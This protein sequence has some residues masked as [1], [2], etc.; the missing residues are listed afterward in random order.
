MLYAPGLPDLDSI[1]TVCEAVTKPVN[2][3]MGMSGATFSLAELAG[4]GAKRISVGSALAR[5]AFGAVVG[6]AREMRSQGTF[7]FSEK[8]MGFAELEGF[9]RN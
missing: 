6:A 5:L 7:R 3:V 9:F 4:A 8:A 1:R 2:V